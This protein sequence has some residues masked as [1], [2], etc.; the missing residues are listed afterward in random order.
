MDSN[1]LNMKKFIIL[2]LVI[3][4]CFGATCQESIVLNAERQIDS[5]IKIVDVEKDDDKRFNAI[6]GI[7][8]TSSEGFPSLM[9]DTYKKLMFI[10][11]KNKDIIA[12]SMA[13]SFAGQGY[14]L[15]GNNI[16]GL[17]SH[18]KAI[19]L[20]EKTGNPMVLG[21]AQN[22]MSHIYKDR[23]ENDKALSLYK[24]AAGNIA[25]GSNK[26][27]SLW[28]MMN[29]G[30]V[31]LNA[32]QLDSSLY[33]SE[34]AYK[35]IVQVGMSRSSYTDYVLANI[36]GVYSKRGDIAQAE[37]YFRLAIVEAE[38]SSSPRFLNNTA[39]AVAEH[40]YRHKQNDSAAFYATK[41]IN[42]VAG[43]LMSNLSLKPARLLTQIYQ[44]K[45]SDSTL[46]YLQV[47]TAA[48]DS[49]FSSRANQQ[50][51]MLTFEEDQRQ[52]DI[53]AEKINYRNKIRTNLMLAGLAIALVVAFILYRNNVQRRK[54]NLVLEK[55]LSD[56]K[57]TQMQLIQSEKMASLGELT[58][59]IAHEIQNP[60]NFVNNF[61][62]VS[63]ELV[64]EAIGNRLQAIGNSQDDANDS[65]S[66]DT[67][68]D[69]LLADIKE[70]LGKINH[71]G[72]RADAIVKGML[73]HSRST[74][75]NREL[76]D[77]NELVDEYVKLSFH[78]FRGKDIAFDVKIQTDFDTTIG[79]IDLAPQEIGRVL[80]N[81][82]N[83][84]FYA[85]NERKS[86]DP[87]FSPE[88]I[89]QTKNVTK[90]IEISVR[91]NGGGIPESLLSKIF[92]PF[93]TTKPTGQGTGLGLSLAYDI[94]KAHGG[95]LKVET[96]SGKGSRFT[97]L[98]PVVVEG[99]K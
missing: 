77:V 86:K 66:A 91:D 25:K 14:R 46:K 89:V 78:A 27:L 36:A 79:A 98:L 83:N 23:E 80:L 48:N 21:Y 30:A 47:Y 73:Q 95:E 53:A 65:T 71:H 28:P 39:V 99:N 93:F 24:T 94:V 61:A 50:L 9:F 88:V 22:Q 18:H 1:V 69:V 75:G 38:K 67:E 62:E 59:G 37:K 64:E 34:N 85:V 54:T 7:Y 81:I 26:F 70:N 4:C 10:A 76:T 11:E 72:K 16:K 49:L 3:N 20:A 40:F 96:E 92:Q 63:E 17:E 15:T 90:G 13:W 97:V 6:L 57:S 31:Y 43:T 8:F 32:N 51:Q 33:Y 44:N 12:E 29:L 2:L 87:A 58:A 42:A 82:L 5:I 60:L 52:R 41:A 35:L 56:L 55:A 84:A 68:L 74:T 45:N 19:L